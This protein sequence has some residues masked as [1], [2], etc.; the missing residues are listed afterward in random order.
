VNEV[1]PYLIFYA[2]INPLDWE[3]IKQN[4]KALPEN[5][6]LSQSLSFVRNKD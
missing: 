5:W 3:L 1:I 2:E 6:N 4:K